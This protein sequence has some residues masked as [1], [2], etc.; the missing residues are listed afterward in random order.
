MITVEK[1]ITKDSTPE[2]IVNYFSQILNLDEK[3][4][5][6]FIEENISGEILPLLE[7][8]DFEK[9]GIKLG[10]KKKIQNFINENLTRLTSFNKDIKISNN[11]NENDVKIFFENYLNFKNDIG[12]INGKK[13]FSLTEE[14]MKDMGLKLGQRK[15]LNMIIKQLRKKQQEL[16][17]IK[18]TKKSKIQDVSNFLKN[19]FNISDENIEKMA[20]DGESLFLLSEEDID[21]IDY[22]SPEIKIALK[23]YLKNL[24]KEE[25]KEKDKE[26][27]KKEENKKESN[28]IENPL[29]KQNEEKEESDIE[30]IILP[31][32][33][34]TKTKDDKNI[35]KIKGL[36]ISNLG[37]N[38]KL[39][40]NQT[41][42]KSIDF[43][44]ST[45]LNF[46]KKEQQNHLILNPENILNNQTKNLMNFAKQN[47]NN[48]SNNNN[49]R[50]MNEQKKEKNTETINNI[51]NKKDDI[52]KIKFE[53]NEEEKDNINDKKD[54]ITEQKIKNNEKE[55]D[56]I[57]NKKV[58]IP[59]IKIENNEEE[60]NNIN[61]KKDDIPEI[62]F[63]NNEEGKYKINNKKDDISEIKFENNEEEKNNNNDK[64]DDK[65][66]IKNEKNEDEKNNNNEKNDD[67]LEIKNEII[68]ENAE[69]N[70]NN[71]EEDIPE[72]KMINNEENNQN[73]KEEINHNNLNNRIIQ[74]NKNEKNNNN[75][76]EGANNKK[77]EI[78]VISKNNTDINK[79]SALINSIEKEN[80]IEDKK[81][82][83]NDIGSNQNGFI[84]KTKNEENNIVIDDL[85]KENDVNKIPKIELKEYKELGLNENKSFTL[86]IYRT[87]QLI[88]DSKY[89][90]FFFLAIKDTFIQNIKLSVYFPDSK[91]YFKPYFIFEKTIQKKIYF[92]KLILVQIPVKKDVGELLVL[93]E[94]KETYTKIKIEFDYIIHNYF[95]FEKIVYPKNFK[96]DI[97]PSD[98][99]TNYFNFF[100]KQNNLDS[101]CFQ[102]NLIK[103]LAE[104]KDAEM[105][106]ESYF[107]FIKYCMYFEIKPIYINKIYLIQNGRLVKNN[108]N[109]YLLNYKKYP[110]LV[111]D[112][113]IQLFLFLIKYY[114][115]Y[116]PKFLQEILNSKDVNYYCDTILNSLY[117]KKLKLNEIIF[118]NEEE[119]FNL[120]KCLLE[121]SISC[122]DI[123]YIMRLS[124]NFTNSLRLLIPNFELVKKA[125]KKDKNF[126]IGKSEFLSFSI[127]ND[128]DKI[129]NI[130]ELIPQLI[131]INQDKDFKNSIDLG[132]LYD[133]LI[134][135]YSN[136]SLNEF[137]KLKQIVDILISKQVIQNE[138]AND[139]YLKLHNKGIN[140]IRNKNMNIDDIINFIYKQDIFY[141]DPQYEKNELRNPIIFGYIDITQYGKDYLLNIQKLKENKIWELYQ[142]ST[143]EM[144]ISFYKSFL[145]QIRTIT[146]F[147]NI[148]DIFPINIID[149]DFLNLIYIKLTKLL[150]E[151]FREKEKNFEII[152]N[153]FINYFECCENNKEKNFN[154]EI[155]KLDYKFAFEFYSY[156]LNQ[157]KEIIINRLK[158]EIITFFLRKISIN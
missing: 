55:K 81:P 31:T 56:N 65:P 104:K 119:R 19:Q 24:K 34:K 151:I 108:E 115:R 10:H 87:Q 78:I 27:N 28:F 146:D 156:L 157:K 94:D 122:Q 114:T 25:E 109:F 79:E 116:D 45:A 41:F 64:K 133:Y 60:K 145:F 99:I 69:K 111:E 128:E 57:N 15:K 14:E 134:Y 63:E 142:N 158:K 18:I 20:L 101:N 102:N 147:K 6:G 89:N 84:K 44:F 127:F 136:K 58:D 107:I 7:N 23:D 137:A 93:I 32:E 83:I 36:K 52:P 26:C 30:E 117:N 9:L 66:E 131:K 67:I 92:L 152:F 143:K 118:I 8:K 121:A 47:N 95:Y 90:I 53:N 68:K 103:N 74:D 3:N 77:N 38:N 1:E 86:N 39:N 138:K 105:T 141:F 12:N 100:F 40:Y 135:F 29:K 113:L 22:L 132:Y 125:L 120:Q 5:N 33:T 129:E 130:C 48:N 126:I 49:N 82:N 85:D 71:N 70:I 73:Q 4:L 62:K 43:K 98:I 124:N 112:E 154:L 54:D 110:E 42:R 139:F 46:W 91:I 51:N 97:D 61:N 144:K 72:I 140:M 153:I 75:L 16:L 35:N 11:S 59:E 96:E 88:F 37:Q 123:K 149:L 148:F 106:P 155:N 17:D 150:P 50:E 76:I 13:L 21:E 2:D 80:N